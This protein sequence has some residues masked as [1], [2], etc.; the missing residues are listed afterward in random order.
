M[1]KKFVMLEIRKAQ[2]P[3][4]PTNPVENTEQWTPV[5]RHFGEVLRLHHSRIIDGNRLRYDTPTAGELFFRGDTLEWH[6]K[7]TVSTWLHG[8]RLIIRPLPSPKTD[9]DRMLEKAPS[10]VGQETREWVRNTLVPF[11]LEK[12]KGD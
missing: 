6:I 10:C 9:L 2:G 7:S 4:E 1:G 8:T 12:K 5:D 11:M 3:G